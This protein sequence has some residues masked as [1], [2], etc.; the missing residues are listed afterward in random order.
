MDTRL[1]L[2]LAA[3]GLLAALAMRA[4]PATVV[5]AAD[6][7]NV[8]VSG[9]T[10][11]LSIMAQGFYPDPLVIHV[12][13]TVK[14][15]WATAGAPHTVTF[16]SDKP[17]LEDFVPG[18]TPGQLVEGP[19][20]FPLGPASPVSYDGTQQLSSGAPDPEATYSV[21]FAKTGVFGY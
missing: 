17:Q 11:D 18:P 19:A 21:T 8:Q 5:K 4:L 20:N 14:W 6:T 2:L 7:W 13:D 12:G 16:N 15:T 9:G 1:L 3:A 10:A